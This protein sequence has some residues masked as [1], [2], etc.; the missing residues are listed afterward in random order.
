MPKYLCQLI[1]VLNRVHILIFS[2]LS[3]YSTTPTKIS[4]P[5][6][7]IMASIWST[8]PTPTMIWL[9]S[10]PITVS[11]SS[12]KQ[13]LYFW[14]IFF[15][16]SHTPRSGS[17]SPSISLMENPIYRNYISS[18]WVG[19][20]TSSNQLYYTKS[21][22]CHASLYRSCMVEFPIYIYIHTL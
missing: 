20:E 17:F 5:S 14:S 2:V 9:P 7:S 1:S 22:A 21:H 13:L 6:P 19:Q 8:K 4:M 15:F 16:F 3:T 11:L 18:F 10:N 12:T